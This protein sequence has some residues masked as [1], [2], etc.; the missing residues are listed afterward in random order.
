MAPAA[1]SNQWCGTQAEVILAMI[2]EAGKPAAK[3]EWT[4]TEA[5]VLALIKEAGGGSKVGT[6]CHNC[7]KPDHWSRE[8]KEP[9]KDRGNQVQRLECSPFAILPKKLLSM[10]PYI[11]RR[12][13]CDDT[14][15]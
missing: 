4:G 10:R 12:C 3:P 15:K 5:E 14:H 11:R 13:L 1:L 6:T 9:R 8:C 7:G 2:K